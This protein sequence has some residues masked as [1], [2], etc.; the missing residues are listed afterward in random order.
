LEF[1]S[2]P[3][4]ENLIRFLCFHSFEAC[5]L[6]WIQVGSTDQP[7]GI[8]LDALSATFVASHAEFSIEPGLETFRPKCAAARATLPRLLP[9]LNAIMAVRMLPFTKGKMPQP[10]FGTIGKYALHLLFSQRRHVS[11][12]AVAV[13]SG[14]R[15]PSG[16]IARLWCVSLWCVAGW[17]SPS[18]N[19]VW[20]QDLPL[21]RRD[22]AVSTSQ[23]QPTQ[24]Y[25]QQL[26][27]GRVYSHPTKAGGILVQ[28]GQE[29]AS[30][31][32]LSSKEIVR[33]EGPQSLADDIGRI[34]SAIAH[35]ASG[36]AL[37]IVPLNDN[38][39]ASLRQ[40]Q[41][42][43]V[44][45]SPFTS[46]GGL[47]RLP[48]F[49]K[50]RSSQGAGRPGA[51][52]I[53]LAS[54]LRAQDPTGGA[55][56]G[57]S[58][59]NG[60]AGTAAQPPQDDPEGKPPNTLPLPQFEGVQIEMLPELD[61]V[62]LRGR[63]QQLTDLSEI[64]KRLDEASRLTR[65]EIEVV[66]VRHV[67]SE[68]LAEL[69]DS[70][71]EKLVGTRQGR[72][73]VTALGSPNALLLIGWGES[74]TS[75]KDLIQKL[76]QPSQIEGEYAVIPLQHASATEVQTQLQGFF[77][78]REG[79]GPVINSIADSRSNA[80]V[81]Q[82]SPR[83]LLEI[84]KILDQIDVPRGGLL[85]SARVFQLNHSLAADIAQA[86][87]D[88]LNTTATERNKSL[89]LVDE[90]GMSI[91]TSGILGSTR[92]TVNDRNNTIVVSCSPETMPLIEQFIEQLD[93][94]GA[95]AK[96]KIFPVRNGDAASLVETLRS[97]IPSSSP[98]TATN[99]ST[100]LS[101]SPDEMSLLPLRFTVDTRGNSIIAIGSDGDL[102]IVEALILRLDEGDG[103]QRKSTVYQLKNSPAVDV[104]LSINEFL[105]SKRQVEIAAP[106][107][108]NPFEQLEREVVVVPEPV[109]NKL[110]LSAT[111]RY[112][113]EISRLI[114]ELDE[115]PPQVMIQV[116]IAEIEL[117]NTDEF[118][119]ETGLQDSV[120]FD[121][122]LLGD[123]VTRTVTTTTSTP[124]GVV[125]A[126]AQEIVAASNNPG[127]NFNN[128]DP[129]GNSGSERALASSN[130][131]GGQGISNFG[132]GR[133][134]QELGFGGLVLSASSENVTFLL[135]A[136][137]DTRRLEIL[138]RPQVLTLDNQQAFIQVGQRI[139]R[140]VNSIINQ[141]GTQNVVALENVGLIIGVTPRI[142]PEG[143]VVMEI[144]AEK[145]KLGPEDEGIPIS[146]AQDGT[147]IRSPRVDTIT[148]Q[149]TVSAAD[150]ETIIL[151]GLIS[152]SIR[153]Q[154]RQVPFLGDIPI[155]KY[156]FSYDYS[157][158]SRTELL[159]I[160]TPHVVRTPG[161][162]ERLK[163]AEF[164]RVSWCEA[165]VFEIHGDVFPQTGMMSQLLDQGDCQVVYPDIDPRGELRD[166]SSSPAAEAAIPLLGPPNSLEEE[167]RRLPQP[168]SLPSPVG[169]PASRIPNA[170]A[171][172][173]PPKPLRPI[174]TQSSSIQSPSISSSTFPSA[175]AVP[176]SAVSAN[177]I[178]SP[179]APSTPSPTAPPN[180][181][182]TE[183][184]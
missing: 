158:T 93:T 116:L 83:D 129:L 121:R 108:N 60:V 107:T 32:F 42:A 132:V 126:T 22:V 115:Q 174:S 142:S 33:I 184:R 117:G 103:T 165:D 167:V 41:R 100:Q 182:T 23:M 134:N 53:Q 80:I 54:A 78:T 131:V 25:L 146:I 120:L 82:A 74:M 172:I 109:Q 65:P 180:S 29:S 169:N 101:S 160:L 139:P 159:I 138:S 37:R 163:Q 2:R 68:A 149:A 47:S 164:A 125:T 62:I 94:P 12:F 143:N 113:D 24:A 61:A 5:T 19:G 133:G 11:R 123:L 95:V 152:R 1:V 183:N 161:D 147:V 177:P 8:D 137:Q 99:P 73:T 153:T 176:A 170:P 27:Q 51:T 106:G 69:I 128:I 39:Q 175:N 71:Q 122:S 70:I 44:A 40:F 56:A 124:A 92:I 18:Q 46:P 85:Q 157:D 127:F 79:L 48:S 90:N 98:T 57:G 145:S 150:G 26:F 166:L 114:E 111:P 13:A 63:D 151:G 168:E 9:P 87:Q 105:R 119:V 3:D 49:L 38:G 14:S 181:N 4:I 16:W 21:V 156:L 59:G 140:I 31:E 91:A 28:V 96:I 102:R 34:S 7:G 36:V 52:R 155:I 15:S 86:L 72:V 58:G 112:Y 148:A 81:V 43:P 104:A 173:A 178:L 136:L 6:A 130:Q 76:D 141:N 118:G 154:H 17:I 45:T 75:M 171:I 30:I 67:N 110:I 50:Q 66:P 135:R 10:C 55:T 162:M 20:A 179:I 84:K 89:Q 88:A 97:L 77:K 64:I 35:S 144:D